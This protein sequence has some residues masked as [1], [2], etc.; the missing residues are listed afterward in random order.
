MRITPLASFAILLAMSSVASADP[1]LSQTVAAG[2]ER[3]IA[4][5]DGIYEEGGIAA[6]SD[7]VWAC[8]G[9]LK[10]SAAGRLAEC[11]AL[12]IVSAGVDGQAVHSLGVPPYKFFS[13]T[14]PEGRILAGIK[15][16]G[17][18]AKEKATFDRALEATL[19]SSAAEFMAE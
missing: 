7:A 17:L 10:R 16:V 12:D 15:T 13:G 4:R 5:F 9:A 8:Y 19:A 3:G 6:A 14:G 2:A 18:S 1:D 11:A